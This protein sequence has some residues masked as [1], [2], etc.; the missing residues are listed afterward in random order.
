M[1]LGRQLAE[2][3]NVGYM[4]HKASSKENLPNFLNSLHHVLELPFD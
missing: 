4:V 3:M 1:K 2:V